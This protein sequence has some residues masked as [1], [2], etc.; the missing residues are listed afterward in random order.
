M[1]GVGP[2]EAT[3]VKG[4]LMK[5]ILLAVAILMASS[6]FAQ[7][8]PVKVRVVPQ[9]NAES[10]SIA[11]GL[12]GQIGSSLRYALVTK[13]GEADILLAVSC[14]QISSGRQISVG[15]DSLQYW[16]VAGMGNLSGDLVI[17]NESKVI[18]ELFNAFV[19]VTS[20]EAIPPG[21][22]CPCHQSPASQCL[23]PAGD[24]QVLRR[25]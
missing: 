14:L 1:T 19:E 23:C 22:N 3:T 20:D 13:T 5:T 2:T 17:G 21:I 11:D 10:R 16:P 15:D 18:Q 4:E 7:S 9:D 8:K 12:A 24:L 6:V 25:V